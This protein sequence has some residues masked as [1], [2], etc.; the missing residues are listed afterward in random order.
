M[1]VLQTAMYGVFFALDYILFFIF[2]EQL[3]VPMYFLIGIWGGPRREYAAIK[4]FIYTL[5]GSDNI[6]VGILA[7]YLKAGLGTFDIV[8]IAQQAE[9]RIRAFSSGRS[10]PSSSAL[11]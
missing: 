3:L 6:L 4:F 5:L 11:P 8:T 1:L 2:L 7:T 9:F 10:W